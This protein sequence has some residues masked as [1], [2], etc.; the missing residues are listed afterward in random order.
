MGLGES[1]KSQLG[2]R[3][4]SMLKLSR[5]SGKKSLEVWKPA[6]TTLLVPSTAFSDGKAGRLR[7]ASHRPVGARKWFLGSQSLRNQSF[8]LFRRNPKATIVHQR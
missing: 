3:G 2:V 4:A 8:E 6:A 7:C 5:S 1:I